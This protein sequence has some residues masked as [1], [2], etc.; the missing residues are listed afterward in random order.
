[1]H[2][3]NHCLTIFAFL[4]VMHRFTLSVAKSE[5]LPSPIAVSASQ[6]AEAANPNNFWVPVQQL[7]ALARNSLIVMTSVNCA[8]LPFAHNW[9]LAMQK[10]DVQNTLI[11]SEDEQVGVN[12]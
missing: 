3:I 11:V 2:Q 1:M 12:Q 5:S 4:V 9:F 7:N 8:Y 10:L 6:S